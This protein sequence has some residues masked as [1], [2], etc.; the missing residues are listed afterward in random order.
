MKRFP[1]VHGTA[2]GY[3]QGCR[4]DCPG[5][6]AG[7]SCRDAM[8]AYKAARRHSV[9]VRTDEGCGRVF[10]ARCVRCGVDRL[11]SWQR[12]P[13]CADCRDVLSPAEQVPWGEV[14]ELDDAEMVAS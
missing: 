2:R 3:W 4:D 5:D 6:A 14:V 11:A 9:V 13:L 7:R 10:P 1:L 12:H 8:S